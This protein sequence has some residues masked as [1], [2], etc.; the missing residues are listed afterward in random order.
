M[1]H[2]RQNS[3]FEKDGWILFP[4]QVVDVD[5]WA[6]LSVEHGICALV[7]PSRR[8]VVAIIEVDGTVGFPGE[9]HVV[10]ISVQEYAVS[11][12]QKEREQQVEYYLSHQ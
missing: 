2:T 6:V 9:A 12:N 11:G 1:A 7:I 5:R 10:V 3:Q 4:V 8:H